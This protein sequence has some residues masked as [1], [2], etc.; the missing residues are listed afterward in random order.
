MPIF[1]KFRINEDLLGRVMASKK[2]DDLVFISEGDKNLIRNLYNESLDQNKT[3]K[4][5]A[6]EL[7]VGKKLIK[8]KDNKGYTRYKLFNPNDEYIPELKIEKTV[9]RPV[10]FKNNISRWIWYI[11]ASNKRIEAQRIE[12]EERARIKLLLSSN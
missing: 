7:I 3:F 5:K 9:A 4:H 1:N 8:Y 11:R 2:N 6:I 10:D 12:E